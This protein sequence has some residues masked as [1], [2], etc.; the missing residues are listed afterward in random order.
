M[1]FAS[2]RVAPGLELASGYIEYSPDALPA[3]AEAMDKV[4]RGLLRQMRA[5]GT[6]APPEDRDIQIRPHGPHRGDADLRGFVIEGQRSWR[7]RVVCHAFVS[8]TRLY[9]AS[10]AFDE[11]RDDHLTLVR[12][13][14]E[15]L[16]VPR[17]SSL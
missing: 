11:D 8:G 9:F 7:V 6:I 12:R 10:A 3:T 2:L 14:L 5:A 15:S 16:K 13:F 1:Q 17:R 4:G